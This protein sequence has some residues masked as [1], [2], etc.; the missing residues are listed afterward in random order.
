MFIGKYHCLF[1]RGFANTT[2]RIINNSFQCFFILRIYYNSQISQNIFYLFALIE[3][4]SSINPVRDSHTPEAFF[5]GPA[6]SICP[7]QNS[8]VAVE[9]MISKFLFLYAVRY[10]LSLVIISHSSYK[11]YFF[12]FLILCPQVFGYLSF[13]IF[14]DFVGYVQNTLCIVAYNSD[15]LVYC[16]Q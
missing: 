12:A 13:I 15:V 11:P 9:E 3:T 7:V 6:L 16:S 2:N 14:Y 4:H 8:K 1:N 5:K 10:K